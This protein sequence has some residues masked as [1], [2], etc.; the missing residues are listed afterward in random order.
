MALLLS[1]GRLSALLTFHNHCYNELLCTDLLVS[2]QEFLVSLKEQCQFAFLTETWEFLFFDNFF[3]LGF[4]KG[5]TLVQSKLVGTQCCFDHKFNLHFLNWGGLFCWLS[6][7]SFVLFAKLGAQLFVLLKYFYI[8]WIP[9]FLLSLGSLTKKWVNIKNISSLALY[10]LFIP[11]YL[12]NLFFDNLIHIF[13]TSLLLFSSLLLP[14]CQYSPLPT[15]LLH[16]FLFCFVLW[17]SD[18]T[19]IICVAIGLEISWYQSEP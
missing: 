10:L 14:L 4:V 13:S 16:A 8:F 6:V 1:R 19:R 7:S 18:F 2:V 17:L 11:L 9:I 3:P 5:L 15:G 12:F